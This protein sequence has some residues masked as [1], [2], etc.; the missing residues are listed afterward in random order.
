MTRTLPLT[1][2]VYTPYLNRHLFEAT[3]VYF[4]CYSRFVFLFWFNLDYNQGGLFFLDCL[5]VFC[6]YAEHK[7]YWSLVD[8][9]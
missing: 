7:L 6:F 4:L 9:D 2:T 1:T 3:L 8:M 5:F